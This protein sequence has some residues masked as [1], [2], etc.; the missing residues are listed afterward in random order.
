MQKA[1]QE[2]NEIIDSDNTMNDEH[3]DKD[4]ITLLKK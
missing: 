3:I 1:I 4:L 2:Y